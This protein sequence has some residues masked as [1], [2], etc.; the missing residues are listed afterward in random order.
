[1]QETETAV[2]YTAMSVE[3]FVTV[4]PDGFPYPKDG[5]NDETTKAA[6]SHP[7]GPRE[8]WRPKMVGKLASKV[9]GHLMTAEEFDA[10]WDTAEADG[11]PSKDDDA[12][13]P[14]A[15]G[16]DDE[17]EIAR[18]PG[19]EYL[20]DDDRDTD[21]AETRRAQAHPTGAREYWRGQ[22]VGKVASTIDGHLLTDE[23]FD[24]HVWP[25]WGFGLMYFGL[26]EEARTEVIMA[27]SRL[28]ERIFDP[29]TDDPDREQLQPAVDQLAEAEKA[30][31]QAMEIVDKVGKVIRH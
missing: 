18:L 1:M 22:Q 26:Y 21:E 25:L 3:Q 2:R 14:D 12:Y 6:V 7:G 23:E 8:Y 9:D 31:E 27:R 17:P 20:W 29:R 11:F 13:W 16:D 5:D 24:R 15:E 28:E 10:A 30:I 4:S 19:F